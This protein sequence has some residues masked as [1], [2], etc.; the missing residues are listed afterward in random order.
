[1]PA[2]RKDLR[3]DLENAIKAARR[4]AEAGAREALN[5]LA[6][7]EKEAFAHMAKVA[8][9]LRNRLRAR[10]R[11]AGDERD[12]QSGKQPIEHLARMVAYEHWHRMLFARFLAE[13]GLLLEPEHGVPV[14]LGDVEELARDEKT[15][16]WAL[17]AEYAE[18]M[19]PQIFRSDDAALDVAL[20][21]ETG[22]KLERLLADLPVDVFQADDSLGWVYQFW[23]A[24]EKDAVNAAGNKIDAD[25]L[26]AVTQLFTEHYMVEFLLHNTLGAWWTAKVQA[27]GR[28]SEIPLPYLRRKDDGSPA[29]GPFPD[30]PKTVRE[31]RVLDPSC[32]SGHFLVTLLHLLVAM[33]REEEGLDAEEAVHVVVREILHGL[34]IDARC[35]QLAAFNVALAAWRLIGRPV[36]L[37][38]LRI[39][40]SGL[41]LGGTREE[42]L[43]AVGAGDR[44]LIG[45]LYDL[46]KKA[47]ELGSLI[48]PALL[49]NI[50]QEASALIPAV[51][52]LLT[53]DPIANPE[54]HELGV[55]AAGLAEAAEILGSAF[56]LVATNVPYLSR[57]KHS[58]LLRDFTD[59]YHDAAKN[60]LATCFLERCLRFCAP[61]GTVSLV[62][63]ATWLVLSRYQKLREH[64]LQHNAFEVVARLGP[65]A[66]ET[67]TGE[68]VNVAMLVI[69]QR[70]PA[71]SEHFVGL[72][73]AEHATP[74]A[75]DRALQQQPAI[76]LPQANQLKNP[77]ARLL[78]DVRDA[79]SLLK[80]VADSRYGLRTGDLGRLALSFWELPQIDADWRFLQ[81]TV[82]SVRD[83]G[84]RERVLLWQNDRGVL[85]ELADLGIASIQGADAWGRKG[86]AVSL[87]SSLPT[88]LYSGE[89]FDN[90]TGVIW[91]AREEYLQAVYAFCSS[92]DFNSQV[93]KIDQSIKVTNQTL[94]KIPFD[95]LHWQHVAAQK[96]PEGLPVPYSADPS[97]WLFNGQPRGSDHPL[98]VAVA[99]LLGYRWP[100]QTGSEFTDCPALSPDGLEAFADKDGIV[101]LP[102]LNREESAATR[103]RNFLVEA[104][105][106]FDE[107]KLLA[108]AGSKSKTFEDWLRDE[109]F[110]RHCKLF[111]ER[112]FIWHVWDGRP[113]GFHALLNYHSL[114]AGDSAGY[115]LLE[116]LTYAYV[117]DWIRRQKDDATHKK[118]GA[119]DRLIAAET[120]QQELKNILAGEPPYDIFVRWKP[121]HQQPIGWNPDIHDGVR[122]NIRP[123]LSASD[124]ARRGAG[125]LRYAPNIKW[126]KDRGTEPQRAKEAFPWFW[127]WDQKTQDFLG[128]SK[129]DGNRWNDLHYS[130]AAK[131]AAR[132]GQTK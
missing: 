71:T 10:G 78:L 58:D 92:S 128:G 41:S 42:W 104:L 105:S 14:S 61:N 23:R 80:E 17:A 29:A 115:R 56:H 3:R 53:A 7:G 108:D 64:L 107:R 19:L 103:L 47:P 65:G 77:D 33:L 55:T 26:P 22:S 95:L 13:N 101:S 130:T 94:L 20:P 90:G 81:G 50:G 43:A 124:V 25:T 88:T 30:W 111:H 38:S 72:D 11:A 27:T 100:R 62:T 6:I 59:A 76:L 109:F 84:G 79:G 73:V 85:R 8:K 113:D 60:D 57:S 91:C 119:E 32:G 39:A 5:S 36:N 18:R 68:V 44:F 45:Q 96:Y 1:M 46:F 121:L 123:F 70:T 52:D 54:R 127:S 131:T 24:E 9:E 35:T 21:R 117:G 2:L 98:Q 89:I 49:S 125:I 75:K 132:K 120:L 112:P 114:A 48:N 40:C 12:G 126:T 16:V 69:S 83:Y 97:Q 99:R 102:A 66:F 86:V 34:E 118:P 15:D 116:K 106:T 67:I 93:R 110:E 122:L 4:I 129:F 74:S 87:M 63:P 28:T 31:L 37:P 82:E 51:R